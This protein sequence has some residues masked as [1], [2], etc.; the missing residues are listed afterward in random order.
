MYKYIVFLIVWGPS[1]PL[2]PRPPALLASHLWRWTWHSM[3]V[4]S[5]VAAWEAG[6]LSEC[7]DCPVYTNLVARQSVAVQNTE[8][9]GKYLTDDE[10]E[11]K[12]QNTFWHRTYI[13]FVH[14]LVYFYFHNFNRVLPV[15]IKK[16]SSYS[17]LTFLL[18]IC[19]TQKH[20]CDNS[21]LYYAQ[22][23]LAIR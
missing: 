4:L 3:N 23:T 17:I 6:G 18:A 21:F 11:M 16:E 12:F 14:V 5:L 1:S 20:C 15:K 10:G 22:Y 19:K 13:H 7:I 8:L 2:C 9:R